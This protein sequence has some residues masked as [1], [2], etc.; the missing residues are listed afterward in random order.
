[1]NGI[2]QVGAPTAFSALLDQRQQPQQL[3]AGA[4][5]NPMSIAMA[6][7][8]PAGFQPHQ[9]AKAE[10]VA[11]EPAKLSQLEVRRLARLCSC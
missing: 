9:P 7:G 10:G 8:Q 1:M 6:M 5:V 11:V 3:H 2:T 4:F